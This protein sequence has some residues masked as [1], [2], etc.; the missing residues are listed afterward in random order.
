MTNQIQFSRIIQTIYALSALGAVDHNIA[1]EAPLGLAEEDALTE[2]L[3]AEFA[4][5]C[6]RLGAE[7]RDNCVEL[8]A[9]VHVQLEQTLIDR[10][11]CRLAGKDPGP[12]I[13]S[14]LR[15]RL[16][17]PLGRRKGYFN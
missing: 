7:A 3:R 13:P 1:D 9:D 16:R 15:S 14:A 2:L 6:A 12:E 10:V 4:W 11:I 8:P 5:L 17:T